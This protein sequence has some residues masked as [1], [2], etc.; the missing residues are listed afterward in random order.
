[1]GGAAGYR[2]MFSASLCPVVL[3]ALMLSACGPS[4]IGKEN[5]MDTSRQSG[6]QH[7]GQAISIMKIR[8]I[9]AGADLAVNSAAIGPDG[10]IADRH[11]AYHN[12]ISPPLT[13]TPVR[14]AGAYAVIVEDPD[15]PRDKPFVHWLAWNIPGELTE[16]PE[17]LPDT[18]RL[19]TLGNMIQ[20]RND[21]GAHGWFGPRPPPGHGL[22][23]YH[24]QVFALAQ[25]LGM[26]PEAPLVDVLQALKGDTLADGEVVGTYEAPPAQ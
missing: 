9:Q 8:P 19:A 16:L 18:P 17:G 14:G 26:S 22:H 7:S 5:P 25:P 2:L 4:P 6:P 10:R 3:A 24:I 15:A 13:W 1:M 21:N 12:N 23:R 20:G 11:S